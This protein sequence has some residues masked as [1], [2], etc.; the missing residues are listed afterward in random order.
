MID[1]IVEKYKKGE[2]TKLIKFGAVG[3]CNTAVDF[4]IFW[5]ASEWA[6]LSVYTAQILAYCTA[7][8]NSYLLNSSWTFGNGRRYSLWQFIKFISVNLTSLCTSLLLLYLFNGIMNWDKMTAKV[9]IAFFTFAINYS[10]NRLWV[11][12]KK[13]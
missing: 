1:K 3:V 7:T 13:N 5:I 6:G 2:L 9:L 12:Y 10:G 11:F 4:I 8:L